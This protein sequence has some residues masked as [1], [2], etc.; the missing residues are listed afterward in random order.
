MKSFIKILREHG[1]IDDATLSQISQ[2][3]LEELVAVKL[4]MACLD[5]QGR[6]F[7]IP[8]IAHLKT[9]IEGGII[10]FAIHSCTSR[11]QA[12]RFL[13]A[14]SRRF[15]STLEKHG[16]KWVEYKWRDKNISPVESSTSM[17]EEK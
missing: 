5:T 17:D 16:L 6:V 9:I 11:M 3:D 7:G 4:E 15:E 13:Q 10:K 14:T 1:R 8:L 12:R 2:L